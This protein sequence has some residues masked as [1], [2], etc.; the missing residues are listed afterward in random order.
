MYKRIALVSVS[1]YIQVVSIE[2]SCLRVPDSPCV[3][4]RNLGRFVESMLVGD[5][6]N[7]CSRLTRLVSIH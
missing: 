4:L 7:R 5:P 6:T 3:G 2:I 1:L